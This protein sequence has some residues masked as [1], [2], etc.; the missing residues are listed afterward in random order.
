MGDKYGKP[1]T[2]TD[3]VESLK[4]SYREFFNLIVKRIEEL[5]PDADDR[6]R[7]DALLGMAPIDNQLR[8][9][10]LWARYIFAESVAK[11]VQHIN[12][13]SEDLDFYH[14]TLLADEGI[15]S[16]REPMFALSLLKRKADKAIRKVFLDAIYVVEVQA[17]INWPQE[18]EGRTFLAHV[19]VLGWR[20]HR[21]PGNSAKDIRR[22]LGYEKRRRNLAW[23]CQFGADPIVVRHLTSE[24]GWPSF[25]AA[26][27]MK[28]PHS[29]K[30]RI[31]R[32]NRTAGSRQSE[33]KLR[34][35]TRGLRP[36][37]AMRMFELFS[38][39]PIHATSGGVGVGA[40]IVRRCRNRL[41]LWDEKRRAGWD[42]D[43]LEEVPAFDELKFWKRTH[44]RR[45]ARYLA[46]FI[47]GP[48]ISERFPRGSQ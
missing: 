10:D 42:K 36:E 11:E 5:N 1:K 22:E 40:A 24:K 17:L 31:P 20:N 9:S 39:L 38:Q 2:W 6:R 29:A 47:D 41:K 33:F 32:K 27:L 43:G 26:Y 37:M 35:T 45:R 14:L 30:S 8:L 13:V 16:D 23:S 48:T 44:R 15:M 46:F 3:A 12:Q 25:W 21:A 4:K 18:G 19:H 28:A 7:F 34:T